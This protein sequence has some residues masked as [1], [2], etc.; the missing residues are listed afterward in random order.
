MIRPELKCT[1]TEQAQTKTEQLPV[2]AGK[3]NRTC[4]TNWSVLIL[5]V[6]SLNKRKTLFENTTDT[7]EISPLRGLS[8]FGFKR[9]GL[10]AAPCGWLQQ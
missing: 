7:T 6:F 2:G 5:E 4:Q 1:Q 9:S 3:V 8:K 10:I